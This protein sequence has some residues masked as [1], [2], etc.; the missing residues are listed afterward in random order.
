MN[1]GVRFLVCLFFF[2][3]HT[4]GLHAQ[5]HR[6]NFPELAK[7]FPAPEA[8]LNNSA[9]GKDFWFA[10]PMNDNAQAPLN[11]IEIYVTG[12]SNTIVTL[13]VPGQ[14]FSRKKALRALDVVTFSTRDGSVSTAWEVTSSE[15][16]D[17][18]G[19]HVFADAPISVYVLNAKPVT[20]EG[21]LALPTSVWGTEY[22]HLSYYDFNEAR[23]WATG[24]T[25]IASEDDTEISILLRGRGAANTGAKTVKGNRLGKTIKTTLMKGQIFNVKGEASTRG[26][27]D[28]SGTKIT[29]NKPIGLV[30]YVE[31][32]MIPATNVNG[33][34]HIVEMLPPVQS[35]GKR[36]ATVEYKRDNKGDFFRIIASQNQTRWKMKYYDKVSG[37]LLGQREGV[38]NAGEFFED[39]NQYVG[40]G[41]VEGFRGTSV[42]EADKPIL[43]MQYSYSANWDMGDEFDPFMILVTPQEQYIQATVF[44]SPAN[45]AFSTN[46]FN[47]VAEGD[48]TDAEQ[49]KLK[50]VT[51]DGKPIWIR[52]PTF[53]AN[54][55]PGTNLYWQN[56]NVAPGPHRVTSQ[57][58]FGGYIYGFSSFDSYGW[59]AAMA[60][61][62]LDEVDT[63]PPVLTFEEECGDFTYTATEVRSFGPP[64]DTAQIDQGISTI[65]MIDSLSINYALEFITDD[66]I[67]VDPKVTE[68]QFKFKVLDKTKDAFAIFV[69]MD[70]AGNYTIDSVRYTVD[71]LALNPNPVQFGKVRLGTTK[72]MTVQIKNESTNEINIKEIKTRFG[73]E[74]TIISADTTPLKA[75]ES[76]DVKIAY[77]PIREMPDEK[78]FDIDSVLV[79][80]ECAEFKWPVF[81]QGVRPCI[82]VE[83]QWNAGRV[84]INKKACKDDNAAVGLRIANTGTD[85]LTVTGLN[86]VRLPFT[87]STVTTPAFPFKI[88]PKSSV[89]FNSICF[90][91]TE[92]K[93]DTI[94]VTFASDS[95]G[96]DCT[97][98][99]TW[100]GTGIQPGLII[101]DQDWGKRRQGTV[102]VKEV[103]VTNSGSAPANVTKVEL[104][105]PANPNFRITNINPP[106]SDAT[107]F[108]LRNNGD[109]ITVKVE[110]EPTGEFDHTTTIT[111]SADNSGSATGTLKGYGFLPK[112]QATG[113]TF[114]TPVLV[115]SF[116]TNNGEVIIKNTSTSAPLLVESLD[117]SVSGP[118]ATDFEWDSPTT[119]PVNASIPIG[120][121]LSIPVKF[122]PTD[123]GQRITAVDIN[124]DAAPGTRTNEEPRIIT[125]VDVI[126]TGIETRYP[127]I[128]V[129]PIDYGQII[130]CDTKRLTSTISNPGTDDLIIGNMQLM[131]VDAAFFALDPQTYPIT[132]KPGENYIV[133]VTFSPNAQR[134]YSAQ[135]LVTPTNLKDAQGNIRTDFI[136]LK[137]GGFPVEV[138]LEVSPSLMEKIKAGTVKTIAVKGSTA[139][140][141]KWADTKI[142]SIDMKLHYDSDMMAFEVGSIKAG[143]GLPNWTVTAIEGTDGLTVSATGTTNPTNGDFFIGDFKILMSDSA[144]YTIDIKDPSTKDRSICTPIKTKPGKVTL[145]AC[146]I[147]GRL[148]SFGSTAF[149]LKGVSPNPLQS[150]NVSIDYS[151]GFKVATT[152]EIYNSAGDRV[153]LAVNE[154]LEP[155]E[156]R[157]A[158]PSEA[159]PNGNY[160]CRIVA[161][162]YTEV[163]PFIINR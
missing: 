41:L 8:V 3:L 153:A 101:T 34:D 98:N 16:P 161:G 158:I 99:S 1:S 43:V 4:L 113:Y 135:V 85:T 68:F 93:S 125:N 107:P 30:S 88:A 96:D 44:Q 116:A 66:R 56:V 20:S 62:K 160:F 47:V 136:D 145:D 124:N 11:A 144:E 118:H 7:K 52:Q 97:P 114:A 60:I 55:I 26:V 17:D 119:L 102:L 38:L 117:F 79:K 91:P 58:R 109:K 155:G 28:M 94:N 162:P 126:G 138:V 84:P 63:L 6:Q 25:V 137:G 70:R 142:R 9:Q 21:F 76:R 36:Y 71:K 112:I 31:R 24:F 133:G 45:S 100:F 78:I 12:S 39:F 73:K 32:V 42:W 130:F 54:R 10:I 89:F 22:I 13:E 106:V 61:R 151:I 53:L 75:G 5:S 82:A 154:T 19:V 134:Q 143:P 149:S 156:Y 92:E 80:T 163:K 147:N 121:Q 141:S 48:S 51:L 86:N 23:R 87:V 132:I 37:D 129:T 57:T 152:I 157:L 131:G 49:K 139:D 77:T 90:N 104:A 122:K 35:W 148:I 29:A 123:I 65:E 150:G 110:Y 40:R 2:A 72:E 15:V 74:F 81:G 108:I 46:W 146:F 18:I 105:Q 115:G 50:S 128:K 159:L 59:P 33:R 95:Y 64:P 14:G 69:V 120:G 111:A 103:Y 27:F 140:Q 83:P 67:V 127:D